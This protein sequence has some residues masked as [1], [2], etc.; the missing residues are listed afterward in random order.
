MVFVHH[1][2]SMGHLAD[3]LR[4]RQGTPFAQFDGAM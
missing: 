2:D 3:R 4:R 1:R